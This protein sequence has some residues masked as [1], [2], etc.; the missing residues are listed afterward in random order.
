MGRG[1]NDFATCLALFLILGSMLVLPGASASVTDLTVSPDVAEPGDTI[2]ISG[3]ASP[4]EEVWLSS[5]FEIS[6]PVSDGEYSRK[7]EDIYFPAG[8]KRFT[9]TAEQVKNIRISLWLF[10]LLPPVSYPLEGP[11]TA[12]DGSATISISLPIT[13]NNDEMD[14]TG[15]RDVKVYGDALDGATV[16]NVNT[17]S[18]I[19]VTANANGEFSLEINTEGVP[20]GEFVISAG[21][22]QKTVYLGVTPTPTPTPTPTSN[23]NEGNIP[24]TTATPTPPPSPSATVTPAPST[25]PSPLPSPSP[26]PGIITVHID[27]LTVASGEVVTATIRIE[28]IGGAGLSSARITLTYDPDVVTVLS[29]ESSDFDKFTAN[30][31]N[32]MV[33]MI[34]FQTGL[35]GV[36]GDVTFAQ[37]HLKAV[38]KDGTTSALG[39]EVNEL[40]DNVGTLLVERNDYEV[41]AG[42]F[43]VGSA[44]EPEPVFEP[45]NSLIFVIVG[46]VGLLL[47]VIIGFYLFVLLKRRSS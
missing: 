17:K 36:T 43:T 16:V 39:L 4:G 10:P 15:E 23:G 33:R 9:V 31:E 5:S 28:G 1:Y 7:F 11:K 12:I 20:E 38:G 41:E 3:K 40:V 13:I 29:A 6:L 25:S 26:A 47:A 37:L 34:G 8:K 14:V 42:S 46:I 32:G 24:D 22:I 19:K 44:G 27:A 35:D 30:I 2:T 18:E 45:S 21:G